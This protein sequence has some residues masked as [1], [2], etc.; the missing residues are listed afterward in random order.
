MVSNYKIIYEIY[1]LLFLIVING[2]GQTLLGVPQLE[3]RLTRTHTQ[4]LNQTH[5]NSKGRQVYYL[6]LPRGEVSQLFCSS[7][8]RILN[9]ILYMWEKKSLILRTAL[10][11]WAFGWNSTRITSPRQQVIRR[12]TS[13]LV[14]GSETLDHLGECT[15]NNQ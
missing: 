6:S 10:V 9:T 11:K 15:G 14:S 8:G 3:G 5:V 4:D 7:L 12:E 13:P 2:W 1:A